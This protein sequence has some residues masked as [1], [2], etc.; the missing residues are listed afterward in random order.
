MGEHEVEPSAVEKVPALQAEHAVAPA[1]EPA[2]QMLHWLGPSHCHP[3]GQG[4]QVTPS[5]PI[6]NGGSHALGTHFSSL[7]IQ[8]SGHGTQALPSQFNT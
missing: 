1:A 3:L 5:V 6:T 7:T 2:G 8:F 4:T